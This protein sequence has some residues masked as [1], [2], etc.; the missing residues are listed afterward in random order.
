MNYEMVEF[1]PRLSIQVNAEWFSEP[2]D[3]NYSKNRF[4]TLQF[5][6]MKSSLKERKF[7]LEHPEWPEDYPDHSGHLPSGKGETALPTILDCLCNCQ[8]RLREKLISKDDLG[9]N[10]LC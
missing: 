2:L 6:S 9:Q 4:I 10:F 8:G 5:S 1:D 3:A 7:I